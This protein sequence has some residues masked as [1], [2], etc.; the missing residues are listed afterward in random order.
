MA[1]ELLSA[2]ADAYYTDQNELLFASA[3]IVLTTLHIVQMQSWA[4]IE[5]LHLKQTPKD[6]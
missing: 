1:H 3:V 5:K 2:T 6:N 4:L